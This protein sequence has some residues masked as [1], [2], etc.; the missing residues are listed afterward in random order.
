MAKAHSYG[1]TLKNNKTE[2]DAIQYLLQSNPRFRLPTKEERKEILKRLDLSPS[3]SRAYDIVLLPEGSGDIM[4]VSP[5]KWIL[6]E[7]KTTQKKITVLPGGFFFGATENEFK[8]AET[9]GD[10]YKFCFVSLHVNS[11]SYVLL[12]SQDLEKIIKMKRV[13]YQINL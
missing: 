13:Q 12:S 9:L 3:F 11:L 1:A 2:T 10:R 5:D 8:L 7:L 6:I 4:S